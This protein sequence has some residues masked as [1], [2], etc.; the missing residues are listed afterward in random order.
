M[1]IKKSSLLVQIKARFLREKI[2]FAA[3]SDVNWKRVRNCIFGSVGIGIIV[4]LFLP[5]PKPAETSFHEKLEPGSS[6]PP[7][8]RVPQD[9]TQQAL[10][11]LNQSATPGPPSRLPQGGGGVQGADRSA[12]MILTRD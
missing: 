5:T 9:P 3:K 8:A 11:Q 7:E 1:E 2:P 6:A 12:S 4:M 10:D